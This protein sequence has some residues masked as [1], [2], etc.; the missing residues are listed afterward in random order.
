MIKS[1]V[2]D[3][4]DTAPVS[5]DKH[6]ESNVRDYLST[7]LITTRYTNDEGIVL[8]DAQPKAANVPVYFIEYTTQRNEKG[9][10][11]FIREEKD[12]FDYKE[13][14]AAAADA[15][16]KK[17][18][19]VTMYQSTPLSAVEQI[20]KRLLLQLK[21]ET[22]SADLDKPS[23]AIISLTN[24][25]IFQCISKGASDLHFESIDSHRSRIR[26]RIHGRLVHL[27][28]LTADEQNRVCGYIYHN[29]TGESGDDHGS[30]AGHYTSRYLQ[31]GRMVFEKTIH[32]L[33]IKCDGR[34][35]NLSHNIN[36][37]FDFIVRI[38]D[39]TK[40]RGARTFQEMKFSDEVAYQLNQLNTISRGGI[41]IGGATS[42]GKTT[43]LSNMIHLE[44]LR[45][46]GTRKIVTA[47]LP[48]EHRISGVTQVNVNESDSAEAGSEQAFTLSNLGR[49]FMRSDPDSVGVGEIRDNDTAVDFLQ[50]V[51]TGH[52]SYATLH[53]QDAFSVFS[54]LENLGLNLADLTN[55][56]FLS[57]ILYQHLIPELCPHCSVKYKLGDDLPP[58][59]SELFIIKQAL[60]DRTIDGAHFNTGKDFDIENLPKLKAY[61]DEKK[62]TLTTLLAEK[63]TISP[64][65]AFNIQMKLSHMN[66]L[67][68]DPTLISRLE[69]IASKVHVPTN[70]IDIRFLGSGCKK[71]LA[72]YVGASPVAEVVTPDIE[73]L[74]H[75]KNRD[76]DKARNYWKTK[77]HGRTAGEDSYKRILNGTFDPRDI[78]GSLTVLR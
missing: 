42:S 28:S 10:D 73:L 62:K 39:K 12:K 9:L 66:N 77:L 76:E 48:V 45:C 23:Q 72:G 69:N 16:H 53:V 43:T 57:L 52:L 18:M 15:L 32:G 63:G 71:C 21:N 40:K 74:T 68:N 2:V 11:I 34:F 8:F 64:K 1:S 25:I 47:E 13:L 51:T 27:M 24:E 37:T 7:S 31:E 50:K 36:N 6:R 54:R 75:I 29:L 41:L 55:P 30:A 44:V 56:S 46:G 58:R 20:D 4:R 78:E 33:H 3:Q 26:L 59:F 70:E 5:L 38:N 19:S 61:A 17:K 49:K 22:I 67:Y 14:K 65:S 60:F 35:V